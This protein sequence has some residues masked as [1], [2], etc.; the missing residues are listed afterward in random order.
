MKL[1][2]FI[3]TIFSALLIPSFAHAASFELRLD[4]PKTPTNQNSFQLSFTALDFNDEEQNITVRCYKKGPS[5]GSFTQFDTD[6]ILSTGGD[7]DSCLVDSSILTTQGTYSF[8]VTGNGGDLVTSDPVT[9]EY[10][11]SGPSAPSD[12]SKEKVNSCD[13]KIKFKTANDG[14]TVKVQLFR[15][16]TLNISV[17]SSSVIAS[18]NI[19]PDMQGEIVNSVPDCNKNY[20]YVI[21]SV[22]ASDNTSGTVGDSFT[23]TTVNNGTT[24]T[25]TTQN[26]TGSNGSSGAIAGSGSTSQVSPEDESASKLGEINS[27]ATTEPSTDILGAS[28]ESKKNFTKWLLLL[29]AVFVG[30]FGSRFMRSKS[31]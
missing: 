2:I 11:T 23:T 6:K 26:G 24:T 16:D 5:E 27:G 7:A 22:D 17:G 13:Y 31:K 4:E 18:L 19:G 20:N 14:K 10:N 25:S 3:L 12:Y 29:V 15:S 9:V 28:T 8:Y 1:K 30:Y 21:R